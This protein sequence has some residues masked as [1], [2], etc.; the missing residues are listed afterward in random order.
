MTVRKSQTYDNLL[1]LKDAAPST[2]TGA[3]QV[4]GAARVLD[5]GDQAG[6]GVV[7]AVVDVASVGGTTPTQ[8]VAIQGSVDLA[9]T[10]P[11]Q[12]GAGPTAAIAGRQEIGF[13]NDQAGVMYRYIRAFITLGG[14]TPSVS[15]IIYVTKA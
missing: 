7:K 1:L 2:A 15:S 9:F 4:A 8:S 3:A 5:M 13:T 14:T 10:T 11:V 12:L 6:M